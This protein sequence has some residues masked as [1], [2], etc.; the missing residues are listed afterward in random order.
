MAICCIL[1]IAI[2]ICITCCLGVGIGA[3]V[4]DRRIGQVTVV[5]TGATSTGATVTTTN[6]SN[7]TA[8]PPAY[9]QQPP[10]AV[11]YPAGG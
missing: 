2:P 6:T 1:I 5:T 11:A 9:D 10:P 3:A 4:C 8:P 7:V